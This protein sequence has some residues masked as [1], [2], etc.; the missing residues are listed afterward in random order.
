MRVW[1][2]SNRIHARSAYSRALL[3]TCSGKLRAHWLRRVL[4]GRILRG[5]NQATRM[6]NCLDVKRLWPILQCSG[7]HEHD[8]EHGETIHDTVNLNERCLPSFVRALLWC[9]DI[10]LFRELRATARFLV[11][12]HREWH[13]P[14]H[15]LRHLTVEQLLYWS[16]CMGTRRAVQIDAKTNSRFGNIV[17]K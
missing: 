2:F 11:A 8:A 13:P 12:A 6:W 16:D 4:W 5:S 9:I 17:P 15:P 10:M 3:D 7:R 14:P 1:M